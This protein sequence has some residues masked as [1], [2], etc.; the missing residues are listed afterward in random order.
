MVNAALLAD[1]KNY[2]DITWEDSAANAKLDG[3]LSRG[4]A[5][6][7]RIAGTAL[8]YTVEDAPRALLFDYARYVRE[9]AL[10]EFTVNYL[11]DLNA[12]HVRYEVEANEEQT[13]T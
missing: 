7:D 2:L 3:I 1:A 11:P 6:L 9:N 8:D 5:F 10:D 12:L 4:M 13:E